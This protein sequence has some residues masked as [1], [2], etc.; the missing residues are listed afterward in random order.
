MS[1]KTACRR[2]RA[3]LG[4]GTNLG[5]RQ[6]NLAQAVKA[7]DA[8]PDLTVL[9]TSGIY[10]TAPWGL[11]GQPDHPRVKKFESQVREAVHAAGKRMAPEALVVAR[12]TDLIIEAGIS[13]L[14]AEGGKR[15]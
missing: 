10:E 4:L 1:D 8:G 6:E 15:Q 13:F 14:R 3:Y 12:S 7:L 5:D 11:P 2:L 9:R